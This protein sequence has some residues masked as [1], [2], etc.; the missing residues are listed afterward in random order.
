M[1]GDRDSLLTTGRDF[2]A[3]AAWSLP[4]DLRRNVFRRL[5][6]KTAELHDAMRTTALG[7]VPGLSVSLLAARELGCIFVHVPKNGGTSVGRTLF[8]EYRGNHMP[9]GSY[10]LIYEREEFDRSFKFAFSRDPYDRLLS[11]FWYAKRGADRVDDIPTHHGPDLA[12]KPGLWRAVDGVDTFEEFV[13]QWVTTANARRW[14]HFRPQHRF[15]CAPNGKLAVD[16]MGRV[17]N[18]DDDFA[19]ICARLGVDAPLIHDRKTRRDDDTDAAAPIDQY[20]PAMRRIVHDVYGRD[21]EIFGYDT[22][23]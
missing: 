10:Q 18:F 16:F 1:L 6:P 2:A 17:E 7:E 14:E 8:G 5:S 11:G 9:I 15:V 20:T 3:R 19:S 21:F 4:H 22:G 12:R 13:H 23:L